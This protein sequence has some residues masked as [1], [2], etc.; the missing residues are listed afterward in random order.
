MIRPLIYSLAALA[1]FLIVVALDSW[2]FNALFNRMYIKW[3]IENGALI[4]IVTSVVA[5]SWGDVNKN[6]GL[7]AAEPLTYLASVLKFVG[8]PFKVLADQCHAVS[9]RMQDV[10]NDLESEKSLSVIMTRMLILLPDA[11]L[12]IPLIFF[13]GIALFAWLIFIAP[14]QYFVFLICGSPIRLLLQLETRA[15]ARQQGFTPEVKDIP[16]QETVPAGWWEI[17]FASSPV[18]NTSLLAT[19]LFFILG[20]II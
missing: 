10:Q 12:A 6:V 2:I 13:L 18:S 5:V 11:I 19:F 1:G 17:G 4:G 16:R 3:Y 15:I 8:L 20:R 9:V 7:I 14:M